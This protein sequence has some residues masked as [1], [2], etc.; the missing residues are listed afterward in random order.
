MIE[1]ELESLRRQL[2]E[3]C[4]EKSSGRR[5]PREI[6]VSVVRYV[7][8]R[9]AQGAQLM[10]VLRELGLSWGTVRQWLRAGTTEPA[11]QAIGAFRP[12]VLAQARSVSALGES[13]LSLTTPRGYRAEGLRLEQL[14]YL[15]RELS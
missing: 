10:Q 9:R 11:A 7:G 2:S 1:D 13:T 12:V 15:L 14:L 3:I 6:R 4:S 5:Y 8:E